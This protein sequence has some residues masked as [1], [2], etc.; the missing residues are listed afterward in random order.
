MASMDKPDMPW[1][2]VRE[3][4]TQR[5]TIT[6]Y[7][8]FLFGG[9]VAVWLDPDP[10]LGPFGFIAAWFGVFFGVAALLFLWERIRGRGFNEE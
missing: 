5:S 6:L 2:N 3:Y 4:L 8:G 10:R 9:L 1:R 7:L